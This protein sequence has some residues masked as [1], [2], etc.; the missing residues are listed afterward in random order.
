[1]GISCMISLNCDYHRD[2]LI[3]MSKTISIRYRGTI[4]DLYT[5]SDHQIYFLIISLHLKINCVVVYGH[6]VYDITKLRLS[7][8][9]VDY[10][11]KNDLDSS[12]RHHFWPIYTFRSSNLFIDHFIASKNRL[13]SVYGLLVYGITKL[14]LLKGCV[15][16]TV[17]NNLD[18]SSRHHFWPIYT[19][20]SSNIF[21]DHFI[22][23]KNWL[24]SV[25]G[26]S[27]Y[28]ITKLRLLKG[29][30]DYTVK[31]D[32]DSLSR[33]HFWPIYTFRSSNL[34]IDHYIASKNK[35]RCRLWAFRVWYH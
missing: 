1:M 6:F 9:C 21:I 13:V 27:V 28:G 33:H 3:I 24:V 22:A 20:R 23:S 26:N 14:R 12:S 5:P 25:Y 17:K 15:D 19:F 16:Y 7:Q 18:S 10:T 31:N 8:G 32:L 30:F 11:V 34:F 29:C 2:A 4:F 35:L